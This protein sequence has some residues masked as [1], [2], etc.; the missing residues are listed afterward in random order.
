M[1]KVILVTG[2]G[3]S[4]GGELCRQILKLKPKKLILLEMSEIKLYEIK[5]SLCGQEYEP[6]ELKFI[7]GNACNLKFIEYLLKSNKVE[8]IFHCAAYKHVPL[9]EANPIEGIANNIFSTHTLCKAANNY[10][11]EK[12]LFLKL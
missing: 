6:K 12:S 1:N 4:I 10:N 11:I 2:A 8:V 3:G 5:N 7:L 9:L